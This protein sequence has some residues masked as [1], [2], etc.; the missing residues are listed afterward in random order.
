M[1]GRNL[2]RS[3]ARRIGNELRVGSFRLRGERDDLLV[4]VSEAQTIGDRAADGFA[5]GACRVRDR[6]HAGRHS[7]SSWNAAGSRLEPLYLGARRGG[8][9]VGGSGGSTE[10]IRPRQRIRRCGRAGTPSVGSLSV[11]VPQHA[12]WPLRVSARATLPPSSGPGSQASI[13]LLVAR[14]RSTTPAGQ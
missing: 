1:E 6:H 8:L 14:Q 3:G 13:Y 5:A 10:T 7:S 4:D 9:P 2:V 11:I 12:R